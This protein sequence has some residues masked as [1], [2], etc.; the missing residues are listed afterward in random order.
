MKKYD[1]IVIG[2]GSG[3]NVAADV[4]EELGWKVAVVEEGPLGGTCLNRGCIPS[5]MVIHAAD[6]AETIQKAAIFGINAKIINVDFAKVTGRASKMVDK[7]AAE[8]EKALQED[9]NINLYKVRGEF[10][11]P[12]KI[13]VGN[14]EIT[15]KQILIAAGSRPA[16][17]PIP[18][19]KE[20]DYIT[21]TEA[22]RLTQQPRRMIII[23]GGYISAELGHFYGSLGTKV[24]VVQRSSPLIK[25]EDS[26]IAQKF[27]RIFSKKY[28]VMLDAETIKVEQK[29]SIKI[30][31]IKNKK[32]GRVQK[33]EAEALLVATGRIPNTDLL[34]LENTQVKTNKAG[35]IETDAYMQTSQKGVW[36]L[37]DIVGKALFKHAANMEANIVYANMTQKANLK[38]DYSVMPHAI[39]SSP[40]VAGVGLTENQAKEQ[41][42]NYEVRKGFYKNTG[43]GQA[44]AEEDGFV[45]FI[46]DPQKETILGCHIMGP[47]AAT[48]IHEVIVA[49]SAAKGKISAITDSIYIH[50]A[51]SEVI[52]RS[53][54]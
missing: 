39:F 52:Q 29:G 16:I 51:L 31:T 13:K 53:L 40:Q 19:L 15:A 27:T 48:L 50:P 8:I 44:L 10:S 34:K 2:S 32:T 22:L 47:D 36:A 38:A 1:L 5:K 6:V 14:E 45:K 26:E 35:Y 24:T 23:G 49:M 9:K 25:N 33:L 20:T 30:A 21:S 7:D 4:A 46:I 11:E 41:K 43:M 54:W 42:L 37:G 28:N 18:G 17:P 12:Y 3:L